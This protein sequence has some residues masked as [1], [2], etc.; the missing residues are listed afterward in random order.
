MRSQLWVIRVV[1]GL[2]RQLPVNP[3]EQTSLAP[4][5]R[6]QTGQTATR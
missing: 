4:V 5:A 1:L 6:S 2:P 3:G